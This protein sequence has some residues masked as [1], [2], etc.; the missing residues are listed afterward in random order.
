MHRIL[1]TMAV[2]LMAT[3]F[4]ALPGY[5]QT[6]AQPMQTRKE[7]KKVAPKATM[8]MSGTDARMLAAQK[9][10]KSIGYDKTIA[11]MK[12]MTRL[13]LQ[14]YSIE[15][16]SLITDENMRHVE[17]LTNLEELLVHRQ[18]SDEGI[19][20]IAGLTRLRVL[21]MPSTRV[22]DNGMQYLAN[23]TQLDSLVLAGLDLTDAGVAQIRHLRPSILNLT[24]THITDAGVAMLKDMNPTYLAISF[25]NITDASV[26]I[27]SQMTSLQRL[28]IQGH[29]INEQGYQQLRSA[30]PNTEIYYRP[31]GIANS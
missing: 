28:D 20:H 8:K 24:R 18:I 23:L 25:T 6:K 27:L 22:T 15:T 12:T 4:P 7:M 26:P 13:V 2:F 10:L 17:V 9:W 19:R 5:A 29:G 30:L 1:L 3:A 11:Q 21:N 14:K 16:A 31:N